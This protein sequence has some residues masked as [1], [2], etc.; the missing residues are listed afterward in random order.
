MWKR[1]RHPNVVNFLGLGSDSP[2]ISLV[3]PWISN[4]N[5]ITYVRE[6]PSVN[7]LGLVCGYSRYIHRLLNDPD[8]SLTPAIGCRSRVDLSPSA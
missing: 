4:G 6:H 5:L 3:Y 2:P 7:K 8:R 1:L